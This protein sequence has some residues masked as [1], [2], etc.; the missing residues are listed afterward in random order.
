MNGASV[1]QLPPSRP[2]LI[3]ALL[4]VKQ[5]APLIKKSTSWIYKQVAAKRI[6]HIHVGAGVRFD[7]AAVAQWLATKH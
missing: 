7:R 4:T 2:N 6:P 5:L 1:T 3:E